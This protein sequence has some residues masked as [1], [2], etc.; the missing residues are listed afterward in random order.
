LETSSNET[1]TAMLEKE[2][3]YL[4]E[5]ELAVINFLYGVAVGFFI[6]WV[7]NYERQID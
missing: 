3:Q 5:R 1:K 4:R 6:Y 2:V 7:T